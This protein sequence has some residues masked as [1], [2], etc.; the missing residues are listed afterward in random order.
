LLLY[1]SKEDDTWPKRICFP[2]N[3]FVLRGNHEEENLNQLYS[4]VSEVH[5]KFKTKSASPAETCSMY[6]HFKAVFVNLPLACLIGDDILAMHGGISPLL[7]SLK[8]IQKIE[9]PI[10]EFVKGTLACDLV[11]SDPD[12]DGFCVAFRTS[13]FLRE[14]TV[15]IGQLFS[16]VAVEE[17]CNRLE[18][19]MIIR[20]HQV[21][22]SLTRER[23]PTAER[24]YIW[25]KKHR[26]VGPCPR[27]IRSNG[28]CKC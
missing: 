20:G 18:V 2:E 27:H 25:R 8:D 21:S 3:I 26:L 17:T 24:D 15:G 28:E 5:L 14:S 23:V 12:T 6:A 11:W 4:F 1:C 7:G 9:R 10:E 22:L 13:Y 16:K 19:K